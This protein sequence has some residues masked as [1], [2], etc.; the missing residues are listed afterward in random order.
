MPDQQDKEREYA[1]FV[2]D[3]KIADD[4]CENPRAP[5]EIFA[6]PY[7][8]TAVLSPGPRG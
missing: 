1:R 5:P 7:S 8:A 6:I 2:D 3:L 4:S